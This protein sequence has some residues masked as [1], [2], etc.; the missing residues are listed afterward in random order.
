MQI[1]LFL[2]FCL[3]QLVKLNYFLFLFSTS[4]LFA[5]ISGL[6]EKLLQKHNKKS[7][8]STT[9]SCREKIH[10]YFSK[11]K[12]KKKTTEHEFHPISNQFESIH[13]QIRLRE[14]LLYTTRYTSSTTFSTLPYAFIS[15]STR[16]IPTI[17]IMFRLNGLQQRVMRIGVPYSINSYAKIVDRH[18]QTPISVGRTTKSI[19]PYFVL[20][21]FFSV[22]VNIMQG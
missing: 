8:H 22:A 17:K 7:A 13:T 18:L 19:F 1:S 12:C 11:T 4:K 6:L 10:F 5:H 2:V 21:F 20:F 14:L 9:P 3:M 16:R 15:K